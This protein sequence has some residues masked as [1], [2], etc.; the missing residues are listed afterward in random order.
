MAMLLARI[1]ND[2]D[3]LQSH[4]GIFHITKHGI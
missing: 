3:V 1:I 2:N 4:P